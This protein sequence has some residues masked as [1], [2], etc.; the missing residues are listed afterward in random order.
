M[1]ARKNSK[2]FENN[3]LQNGPNKVM[4]GLS[5]RS[6]IA[7]IRQRNTRTEARKA[8]D[9]GEGF[10]R[11]STSSELRR[12]NTHQAFRRV[13]PLTLSGNGSVVKIRPR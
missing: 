7:I 4:V 11:C 8:I 12:N 3:R 1:S 2:L 13:G 9:Q 5:F 10:P 6:R